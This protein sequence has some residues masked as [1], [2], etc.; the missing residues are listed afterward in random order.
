MTWPT[1]FPQPVRTLPALRIAAIVCCR[2]GARSPLRR[3]PQHRKL[4]QPPPS[5]RTTDG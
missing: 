5:A 4:A 3:G 1:P 2:F